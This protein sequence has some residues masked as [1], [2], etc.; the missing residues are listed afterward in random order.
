MNIEYPNKSLDRLIS[1]AK[2]SKERFLEIGALLQAHEECKGV[3]T[4]AEETLPK[5]AAEIAVHA[6]NCLDDAIQGLNNYLAFLQEL[7]KRFER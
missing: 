1:T 5:I 6:A 7:E 3:A 4:L 2:M